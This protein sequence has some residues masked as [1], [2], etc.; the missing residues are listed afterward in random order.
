MMLA[1]LSRPA[2]ASWRFK[3]S[4]EQ[5]NSQKLFELL[6]A[7]FEAGLAGSEQL[8]SVFQQSRNALLLEGSDDVS[9]PLAHRVISALEGIEAHCMR[10]D[11]LLRDYGRLVEEKRRLQHQINSTGDVR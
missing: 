8:K 11:A 9:D 10:Y 2:V 6:Q 4:R 3:M 1:V 7:V 5:M